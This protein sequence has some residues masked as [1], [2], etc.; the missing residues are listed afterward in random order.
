MAASLLNMDRLEVFVWHSGSPIKIS[1]QNEAYLEFDVWSAL[2]KCRYLKRLELSGIFPYS[3]DPTK[4][5]VSYYE[6]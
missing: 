1:N 3:D 2:F 4:S 6:I 5:S